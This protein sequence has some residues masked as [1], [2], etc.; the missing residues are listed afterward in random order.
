[1][2]GVI[3]ENLEHWEELNKISI[4]ENSNRYRRVKRALFGDPSGK[5][6]TFAIISPEN[7]LGLE[8][9]TDEEWREKY[10]KW[11]NNPREYNKQSLD[12]LKNELLADRIKKNG[13]TAMK[14]GG[15]N[16]V[17][18][19]GKYGDN[20]RTFI[21]FNIPLADA[22]AIATNYGQESFFWGKVSNEE[23]TPSTIGY[24]ATTNAC[25]TYNLVEVSNTIYDVTDAED[26]FSKYGFKYR[27]GMREF[28]DDVPEITNTKEFE[29]SFDE[30][31]TFMSRALHRRQSKAKKENK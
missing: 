21:I 14:M 7:P 18:I 3:L 31:R 4:E 6:K 20:E 13:D 27:I 29:E 12:S 16:Y 22:K 25:K 1:M 17:Q 28:G 19:K 8:N 11:K 15:F 10:K 24:Y 26:F 9:T 2:R 23:G 5:I 30:N